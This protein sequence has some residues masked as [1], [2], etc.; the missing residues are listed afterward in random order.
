MTQ[1]T[2]ITVTLTT[3]QGAAVVE[4]CRLRLDK[5]DTDQRRPL[6]EALSALQHEMA[7]KVAPRATPPHT[8]GLMAQI[9]DAFQPR[10]Q[11]GHPIEMD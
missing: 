4:A 2:T 6:K 7:Y 10:F 8:A 1:P 3:K 5:I 9:R 11:D